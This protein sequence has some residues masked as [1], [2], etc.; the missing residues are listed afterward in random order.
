[1]K[2]KNSTARF[3]V[4]TDISY[5]LCGSIT[6]IFRLFYLQFHASLYEEYAPISLASQV[7]IRFC[8]PVRVPGIPDAFERADVLQ[9]IKGKQKY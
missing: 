8:E 4:G 1:M 2:G 9:K 7:G 3:C 5:C 6:Y